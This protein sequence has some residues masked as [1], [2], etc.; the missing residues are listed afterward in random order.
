[1]KKTVS[2][3]LVCML[4]VC[5]ILALSSCTMLISLGQLTGKYQGDIVVAKIT[6]EFELFGKVTKITDPFIG[7]VTV[8]VGE[9]KIS[10]DGTKI[11]LTFNDEAETFDFVTG[12]EG[13]I[14]Y[15]K[16]NGFKYSSIE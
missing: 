15:I 5:S 9:Y 2:N 8:E 11:T 16:L 10:D 4:L 1:M 14:K 12:E 3:I 7:D 6:Y 13:G